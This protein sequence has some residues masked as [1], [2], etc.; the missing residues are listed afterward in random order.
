MLPIPGGSHVS[1]ASSLSRRVLPGSPP[2]SEGR[3]FSM[4]DVDPYLCMAFSL[5]TRHAVENQKADDRCS[6]CSR[7]DTG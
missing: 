2:T 6:S 4:P 3:G 5:F 1:H 7:M